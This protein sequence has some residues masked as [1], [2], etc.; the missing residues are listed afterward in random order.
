MSKSLTWK[1]PFAGR[2]DSVEQAVVQVFSQV[3]RF[4]WLEPYS[5]SDQF[6]TRGSGFFIDARGSIITNAHVVDQAQSIWIQI[7]AF[8]QKIF[9]VDLVGF[10]PERDMALLRLSEDDKNFIDSV[11]GSIPF[12]PLGDSDLL[13]R[14]DPVLVFGYPLGQYRVKSST[15]VVSG[16]ESAGGRSWIQ[17]TAPINPGNSGGPLVD[18]RGNVV[19]IAVSAVFSSQ[20]VGYAIPINELKIILKDLSVFG[21]V[22]CAHLGVVFSFGSDALASSLGNPLPSGYQICKVLMRSLADKAGVKVGDML[23]EFNGLRVDAY[24]DVS[25]PWSTDKISIQDLLSRLLIGAPIN[26]GI[27]R[28]GKKHEIAC[29]WELTDPL[30][31]RIIYPDYEEVDYEVIAGMVVMQLTDDHIELLADQ[32]PYLF[33]YTKVEKRAEAVLVLSHLLPGSLAQLS[34]NLNPGAIIVELNGQKV[35]TLASFRLALRQSLSTGFL[36]VKTE[37]NI[38]VSFNLVEV[39]AEESRLSEYF[40]YQLS[41]LF[42]NKI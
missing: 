42:L 17:I 8:G 25:S 18:N 12:L 13:K 32:A 10:C 7:P 9:F 27:Y 31:V 37:D 19:G 36:M 21:L 24:G 40:G 16:W 41:S 15:G 22:R 2:Q 34:R 33:D 3:V 14:T 11:I 30:P 4:D 26:M 1:A 29:T 39:I 28:D 6:E 38:T 23:Y 5:T 20:N 35:G